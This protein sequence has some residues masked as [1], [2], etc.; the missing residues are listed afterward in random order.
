MQSSAVKKDP[1]MTLKQ[2]YDALKSANPELRAR[3][4]AQ[5]LGVSECELL[6][7]RVGEDAI[8]LTDTPEDILMALTPLGEV[9][10]LSRNEAV[11]HERKGIYTNVSFQSHGPMRMG[12]AVNADIDLRFFMGSWKY[13]FAATEQTRGGPRKSFQFFDQSGD[14]IHKIY[15]TPKSDE[16]AYNTVVK[17]FTAVE[18][19]TDII[20]EPRKPAKADIPDSEI[21]L[22][23]FRTAWR[24]LKDTHDFF[25]LLRQFKIGR[26]QALRLAG[27]E[28]AYQLS[29]SAL[30]N[31]LDLA[32]DKECEI[33]VFVGNPGI[34]QIHTGPVKKVMPHENWYNVMDPQF[35]LHADE[36]KIASIWV[37]LKPTEDGTVTAVEVF[38]H[39]NELIVT[40]FGKRK[41]GIP[42]LTLWREIVAALSRA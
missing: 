11:V 16:A 42:E 13:A 1:A 27:E 38:D 3:N 18:Q 31:V 12:L 9:M 30:R 28:F 33:M 8:R 17:K 41:P 4:A 37:T 20:V 39:Q 6:A 26:L 21:D 7:A 40:F 36:T 10:A 22:E 25:L 2:R 24:N 15:L 29:N 19:L 23:G 35:N 34:I 5:E 14:A 32:R